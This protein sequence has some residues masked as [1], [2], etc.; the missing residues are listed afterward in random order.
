MASR[1][2]PSADE[3][4][5]SRLLDHIEELAGSGSGDYLLRRMSRQMATAAGAR[6]ALVAEVQSPDRL[7]SIAIWS[8]ESYG[9]TAEYPIA[10]TPFEHMFSIGAMVH[11]TGVR[12]AFPLDG[13]LESIGAEAFAAVPLFSSDGSPLGHL[14]VIHD[15]PLDGDSVIPLLRL[16]GLRA[17]PELERLGIE[18][19]LR[20]SEERYRRL[21]EASPDVIYRLRFVPERR[22]EYVSPAAERIFGHTSAEF[23]ADPDLLL[24]LVA[25]PQ[26]DEEDILAGR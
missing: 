3:D 14:A 21:V 1:T 9:E 10:G 23:Y 24:T 20:E 11:A 6:W 25:E 7:R 19:R 5:L 22:M 18:R 13:W 16:F 17:A 2:S 12:T 4:S 8:G 26:G 15:G